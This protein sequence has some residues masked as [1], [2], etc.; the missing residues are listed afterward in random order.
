MIS[1]WPVENIKELKEKHLLDIIK[2]KPK[3]LI[4]GS[5]KEHFYLN[6]KLLFILYSN[7]IGCEVMKTQAACRTYNL[8]SVDN[9]NVC[10]LLFPI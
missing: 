10:G 1:P 2:T 9:R 5:G 7:K 3:I 8:L 4:I 6:N